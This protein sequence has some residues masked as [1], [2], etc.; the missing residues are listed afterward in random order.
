[1]L[2]KIYKKVE[3]AQKKIDSNGN[4][5]FIT[6]FL[7]GYSTTPY[8]DFKDSGVK[9]ILEEEIQEEYKGDGG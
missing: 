8:S 6:K 7:K 3:F 1:M 2:T 4:L 5:A 9:E